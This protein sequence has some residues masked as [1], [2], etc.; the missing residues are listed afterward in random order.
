MEALIDGCDGGDDVALG[1]A[2]FRP[3]QQYSVICIRR[4]SA[5]NLCNRHLFIQTRAYLH[6]EYQ[7]AHTEQ[8]MIGCFITSQKQLNSE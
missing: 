6:A 4:I 7:I 8:V 2:G 5:I 3:S 1:S